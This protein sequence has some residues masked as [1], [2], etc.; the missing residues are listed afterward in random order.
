MDEADGSREREWREV[1][2]INV[3]I[4]SA[5]GGRDTRRSNRVLEESVECGDDDVD[6]VVVGEERPQT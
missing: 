3:A 1:N 4:R 5:L 2:E 6:V